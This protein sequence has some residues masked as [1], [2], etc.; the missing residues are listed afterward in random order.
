M[1]SELHTVR[2]G[3]PDELP[4]LIAISRAADALFASHGFDVT[5]GN[6][7]VIAG[8][9]RV[10]V[11]GDPA[12]GYAAVDSLDS[13][14]HL[15]EIAVDPAAGRQGLGTRLLMATCEAMAATGYRALTLTTFR[16]L[17]FN[18]PWYA[19]HGFRE[20]PPAAWGPQL[21]AQSASELGLQAQPRIVMLRDLTGDE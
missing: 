10:L 7:D 14:A 8:A 6:T 15:S 13:L 9:A 18:A 17:P 2:P 1:T 11:I 12:L 3:R 21:R 4:R 20:L 16:D 5:T 19:R